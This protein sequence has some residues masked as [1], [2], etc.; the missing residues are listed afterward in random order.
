LN[1]SNEVT[2]FNNLDLPDTRSE[3]T[4]PLKVGDHILGALD[5]QSIHVN[6]FSQED[7]LGMQVVADLLAIA[8]QNHQLLAEH[9]FALAAA[10]RAYQGTSQAGWSKFLEQRGPIGYI[11][12]VANIQENKS[13]INQEMR[14]VFQE[15]QQML[16]GD[17]LILPIMIR[18]KTTG[19]LRLKKNS[20]LNW[21]EKEVQFVQELNNQLGQT[22]ETARLFTE[23]QQRAERERLTSEIV[24]RMRTVN[25]PHLILK[26]AL[27]DLQKA[28]GVKQ[29]QIH[30]EDGTSLAV[31]ANSSEYKSGQEQSN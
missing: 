18:E 8:V 23:T 29:A 9:R 1:E 24:N 13:D 11:G 16:T 30:L 31:E 20:N 19:V 2:H 12:S 28:I 27:S 6:A 21:S 26:S 14:E 10:R 15:N 7:L 3:M 4:L 17:T 22:L 25:D 5:V